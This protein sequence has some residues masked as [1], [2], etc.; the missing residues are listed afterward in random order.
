MPHV[1]RGVMNDADVRKAD[2]ADNKKSET[3][4]KESLKNQARL[5]SGENR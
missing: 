4:R 2:D 3:H 5:R 1:V